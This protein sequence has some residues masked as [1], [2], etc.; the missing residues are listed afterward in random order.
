M[1]AN[2]FRLQPGFR[3]TVFSGNGNVDFGRG[4]RDLIYLPGISSRTVR[5]NVA[6]IRG[7]GL[8]YNPGNGAR[9]FDAMTLRNG[10]QILF[11]GIDRIRF[12][13]RIINLSVRPN[14]RYFNSQ[15]N[16]HMMG[17]HNAWRFTRGSSGVLV[18]IQ[19]TG[20]VTN[21]YNY[22]HPD[23]RARSTYV[24]RDNYQDDF[25][26]SHGTSVQGII[27]ARTN[28]RV[29]MSGINWNSPVYHIDVLNGNDYN[30]QNI[31][32]ATQNMINF[33]NSRGQKLIVNMSLRYSRSYAFERLIANNQNNALFVIAT[34][35]ED[36]NRLS[37]PAWLAYYY[38]NVI[39]VGASW[40][41]H[42]KYGYAKHL[43]S[44]FLTLTLG[45]LTMERD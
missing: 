42:D 13:D 22:I 23:L 20:L 1:R 26:T 7:G 6:K 30:D 17:V 28:N 3:R 4:A 33:A 34:G 41:T 19:D 38:R 8:L 35:N 5:F 39:A 25:S 2:I 45:V 31:A 40:G 9:V 43:A 12:A 24:N 32:E 14:D 18:G 16:L 29:G 36:R 15:W 44:E 27:A 37:Y 10:Q 11:E 21:Y